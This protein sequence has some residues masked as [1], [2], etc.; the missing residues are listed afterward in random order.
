MN[1]RVVYAAAVVTVILVVVLALAYGIAGRRGSS[2]TSSSLN[3]L[4]ATSVGLVVESATLTESNASGDAVFALSIANQGNFTFSNI[5]VSLVVTHYRNA[6]VPLD[7]TSL[8][9][10]EVALGQLSLGTS[11]DTTV[12]YP[13]T[14]EW[15]ISG[16]HFS[17]LFT[18]HCAVA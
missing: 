16:T 12:L 11:C 8:A 3:G 13:Y 14:I 18:V 1:R 2:Q 15:V 10:R 5:G 4:N 17:R 7:L 6:T 9:P